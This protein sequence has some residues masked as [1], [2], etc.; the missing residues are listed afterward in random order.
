MH[1]VSPPELHLYTGIIN[2]IIDKLNIDWGKNVFENWLLANGLEKGE[3]SYNGPDCTK[4]LKELLPKLR[5]IIPL[6]LW[7][8][9]VVFDAF[10]VVKDS[11]FSHSL[12]PDLRKI[13]KNFETVY[14]ST[15]MSMF[16][17]L[18]ILCCHVPD[19][20]EREGIG[21]AL[22]S[23]QAS[24]SVHHYFKSVEKRYP[25]KL[26]EAVLKYNSLHE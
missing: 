7:K 21:M 26:Y 17:K 4:F 14:L 19:F 10:I 22:F 3:F 18:H 16:P 6:N 15:G 13:I 24:E 2:H 9:I 8:Y 23:E 1:R 12:H 20:C 5:E 11:C 25:D